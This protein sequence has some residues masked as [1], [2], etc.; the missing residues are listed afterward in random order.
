MDSFFDSINVMIS[1]GPEQFD[2]S[3]NDAPSPSASMTAS[4][5]R[6]GQDHYPLSASGLIDRLDIYRNPPTSSS[7]DSSASTASPGDNRDTMS[8][9]DILA[10]EHTSL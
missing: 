4:F 9:S 3:I 10:P 2:E 5:L 6:E 1:H 7:D 8:D